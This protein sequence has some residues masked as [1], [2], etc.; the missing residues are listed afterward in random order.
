MTFSIDAKVLAG[1]WL[2]LDFSS[3]G[4]QEC[5]KSHW[6]D[7]IVLNTARAPWDGRTARGH[8]H[9][10]KEVA[11]ERGLCKPSFTNTNFP[12][13]F[14]SFTP[15]YLIHGALMQLYAKN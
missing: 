2:S 6:D 4:H 8:Q 13:E 9:H 12:N 14:D 15:F 7:S 3:H 10:N 11:E 1:L 5:V